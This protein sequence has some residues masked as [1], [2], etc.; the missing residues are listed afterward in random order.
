M[1]ED[2]EDLNPLPV[3]QYLINVQ[4]EIRVLRSGSEIRKDRV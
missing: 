3:M 4:T 1:T 2:T